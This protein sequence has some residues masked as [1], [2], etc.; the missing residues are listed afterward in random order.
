[1]AVEVCTNFSLRAMCVCVYICTK[2]NFFMADWR[3]GQ[4]CVILNQRLW[5]RFPQLEDVCVMNIYI[6]PCIWMLNCLVQLHADKRMSDN[7]E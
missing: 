2:D 7:P 3:S 1:M 4:P 6:Y 5:V